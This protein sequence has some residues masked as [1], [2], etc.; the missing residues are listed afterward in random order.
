[1]SVVLV[2]G[3]G[4]FIGR[5]LVRRLLD[6][7]ETV[8]GVDRQP[9]EEGATLADGRRFI[10]EIADTHNEEQL[11]DLFSRRRPDVVVSLAEG[12]RGPVAEIVSDSVAGQSALFKTALA[13]GVKRVCLAS[14]LA[15]YLGLDGPFQEDAALPVRST[16]HIGAIKKACEII[17][18]WY[19]QV[20]PLEVVAVRLANIYGPRYHSM[21]N[22][23]SRYLFEALGRPPIQNPRA[24]DADLYRSLADFCHVDDCCAGISLVAR[25]PTLAHRIYNIGGGRGVTDD[26]IRRA[27][28]RAVGVNDAGEPTETLT[29]YLDISRISD[30]LGYRPRHDLDSGILAYRHWLE[31][32]PI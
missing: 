13:T 22:T 18:L 17:A 7:G 6:D 9:S 20:T 11:T 24:L 32:H 25:A 10:E 19:D 29:T 26:D 31:E 2:T 4:G 23:P 27:V 15:V 1:M 28:A 8:V 14:S 16:L 21:M 3:S 30:E 12:A 5:N